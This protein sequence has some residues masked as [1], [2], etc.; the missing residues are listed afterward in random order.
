MKNQ[1]TKSIINHQCSLVLK[2]K[3]FSST[4][5]CSYKEGLTELFL[6]E[7]GYSS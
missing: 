5:V 6:L 4:F 2:R 1:I 3:G 7:N